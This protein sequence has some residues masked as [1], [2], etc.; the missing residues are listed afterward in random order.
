MALEIQ[1]NRQVSPYVLFFI[2]YGIQTGI[3]VINYQR[4]ITNSA[5]YDAWLS[6]LIMGFIIFVVMWML[7]KLLEEHQGDLITIHHHLFGKWIGGFLSFL[8]SLYFLTMSITVLNTYVL[9]VQVWMFPQMSYWEIATLL[10]IVA[11][12][13]ISGG[14]RSIAGIAFLSSIYSIPLILALIAPLNY[15]HF[16]NLL[17]LVNHSVP[18]LINAG[19]QMSLNYEGISILLLVY[20]FIKKTESRDNRKQ[21][22]F[23]ATSMTTVVYLVVYLVTIVYFNPQELDQYLWPTMSLWKI[24]DLPFM[25]RFEYIGITIWIFVILPNICLTLWGASRIIKRLFSLNQRI[26]V[27]CLIIFIVLFGYLLSNQVELDIWNKYQSLLGLGVML[28][29]LP[30]LYFYNLVHRKMRKSHAKQR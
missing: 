21:W 28:M 11:Y 25:E 6:I 15:A 14:L 1:E 7:T 27:G 3:G 8:F 10:S 22:V 18:A 26:I 16:D 20:P 4:P 24:V 23:Y 17:P 13:Y 19:K 2:I 12:A 29:Y 30:F 5:G 9:L